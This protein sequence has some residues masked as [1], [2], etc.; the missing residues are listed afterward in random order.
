MGPLPFEKTRS[1][2]TDVEDSRCSV[3]GIDTCVDAADGVCGVSLS[4]GQNC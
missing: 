2:A 4:D 1:G 3:N